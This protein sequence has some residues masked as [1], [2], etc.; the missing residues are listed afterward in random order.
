MLNNNH[1]KINNFHCL[2]AQAIKHPKM[3][4]SHP[5]IPPLSRSHQS[6]TET[7]HIKSVSKSLTESASERVS[8]FPGRG[9]GDKVLPP[10]ESA[11]EFQRKRARERA[12]ERAFT[13]RSTVCTEI[14][15]EERKARTRE[16]LRASK[17]RFRGE[18][19]AGATE[20]TSTVVRR[21]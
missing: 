9:R 20:K 14:F 21:G 12:S 18:G 3:K 4:I 6:E 19:G 7:T 8:I 17:K 15:N 10:K 13:K 16:R 11:V 2:T 1:L 5:P